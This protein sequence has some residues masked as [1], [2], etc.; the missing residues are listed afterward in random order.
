MPGQ[1]FLPHYAAGH[2]HIVFGTGTFAH[3][4]GIEKAHPYIHGILEPVIGS[5]FRSTAPRFAR[6]IIIEHETLFRPCGDKDMRTAATG[7]KPLL[8]NIRSLFES[9]SAAVHLHRIFLVH[10]IVDIK[11]YLERDIRHRIFRP[12]HRFETEQESDIH[13]RVHQE[14]YH[15]VP[16]GIVNSF[17]VTDGIDAYLLL[18][19]EEIL[20]KSLCKALRHRRKKQ[21]ILAI[22]KVGYRYVLT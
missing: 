20:F 2:S 17:T 9:T 3:I 8:R 13:S 10:R 22:V 4:A 11:P 16:A 7:F 14:T 19:S 5:V 1:L 21:R 18:P 12:V 6:V 15:T